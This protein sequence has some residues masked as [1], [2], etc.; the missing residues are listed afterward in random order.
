[1]IRLQWWWW[2]WCE[3]ESKQLAKRPTRHVYK[4]IISVSLGHFDRLFIMLW[5]NEFILKSGSTTEDYKLN[6]ISTCWSS[7]W[8]AL[9]HQTENSWHRSL[10][11]CNLIR[12]PKE[13]IAL[14]RTAMPP[15]TSGVQ[16][17]TAWVDVSMSEPIYVQ[18]WTAIFQK[19]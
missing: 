6:N 12:R 9:I 18:K 3:D 10:I 8:R 17:I 16:S 11:C 15:V 13:K 1:M 19:L 7:I 4:L 5:F 2:V 14:E